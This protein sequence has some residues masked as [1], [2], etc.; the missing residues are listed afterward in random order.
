MRAFYPL[1]ST[2]LAESLEL[3]RDA[4]PHRAANI[5]RMRPSVVEPRECKTVTSNGMSLAMHA[6]QPF[7]SPPYSPYTTTLNP[8]HHSAMV[9]HPSHVAVSLRKRA[10][11]KHPKVALTIP[12]APPQIHLA[13]SLCP[14]LPPHAS[15]EQH[16]HARL[17]PPSPG[18]HY[19]MRLR[20]TRI[21]PRAPLHAWARRIRKGVS[22]NGG[23]RNGK[24]GNVGKGERREWERRE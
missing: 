24:G 5:T 21:R 16:V 22:G 6:L 17:P 13:S 23:T 18:P 12:H 3:Y 4:F 1:L 2:A 20:M 11:Y 10:W 9:C 8:A 7:V 15:S 19:F 14:P